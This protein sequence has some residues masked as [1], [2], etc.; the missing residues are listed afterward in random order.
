VN[1]LHSIGP[2]VPDELKWVVLYIRQDWP[3]AQIQLIG[4]VLQY[5]LK[6]RH[7]DDKWMTITDYDKERCRELCDQRGVSLSDFS[8]SMIHA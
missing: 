3:N 2:V 4:N 7:T 5:N 6:K 8:L 1:N